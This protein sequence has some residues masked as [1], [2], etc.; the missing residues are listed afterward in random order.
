MSQIAFGSTAL[1]LAA[2]RGN[3]DLVRELEQRG[4][5]IDCRN[6][7]GKSPG[8]IA[9]VNEHPTLVNFISGKQL[10]KHAI[11]SYLMYML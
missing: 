3:L 10:Y 8:D 6:N 7:E 9:E 2:M 4:A 11:V 5:D 1:H